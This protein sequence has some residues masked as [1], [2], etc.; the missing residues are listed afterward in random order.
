MNGSADLVFDGEDMSQIFRALA[1]ELEDEL[2]RSKVDL[3]LCEGSMRL[4]L[5]S[6]DI[7][8][9]RAALNTWIRLVKIAF[10]MQ[11]FR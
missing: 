6:D 7:V 5:E 4:S 9:L 2:M 1:P 10:E 3:T 11:A 8:S